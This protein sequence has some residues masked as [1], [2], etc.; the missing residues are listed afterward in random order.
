V[1]DDFAEANGD[2]SDSQHRDQDM[3]LGHSPKNGADKQ[4]GDPEREHL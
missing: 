3:R 4:C 1:A 2:K